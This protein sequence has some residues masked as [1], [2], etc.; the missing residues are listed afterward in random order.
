M[1]GP[2]GSELLHA[3]TVGTNPSKFKA[4]WFT[5]SVIIRLGFVLASPLSAFSV[6]GTM[7]RFGLCPLACEFHSPLRIEPAEHSRRRRL[8]PAQARWLA[9]YFPGNHALPYRQERVAISRA[10]ANLS[11]ALDNVQRRCNQGFSGATPA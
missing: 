2:D 4:G 7:T 9:A 5:S 8:Q 10:T 11:G 1:L 6:R 3:D